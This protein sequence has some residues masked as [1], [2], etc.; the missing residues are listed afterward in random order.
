MPTVRRRAAK[1]TGASSG[2]S[3]AA[4]PASEIEPSSE[5]SVPEN[6]SDSDFE[7]SKVVGKGKRKRKDEGPPAKRKKGEIPS[8]TRKKSQEEE[9]G[10]GSL[11]EVVKTGKASLQAVVDDWIEGYK[12]DR[13]AALLE[14]I[15]FFIQCSGCRGQITPYMYANMEHAEIIRKMTEEFDE[16]SGDYPLIMTG[17]QWK[18]FRSGFCEFVQVL[19]RQCQYSIIYDQYMMDNVISLLTGL[20]DSQVRAFRHTST[21]AAMKLMTALVDVALNLSINLDNTQRQYEAERAKQQ[22]KRAGDRLELL[23]TKRQ[24]LEENQAEIRN[25]LTYIFKGVFVHRYRDT[26]PEIRSICMTEIGVWMKKYPNMFLDDSYLKYVGWTL[27][28]KVGDVRNCCLKTL[29]PLHES[30]DLASKLELFTNRF[31]DRIVEMTLDKEYDVAVQAIKLVINILKNSD[32]VLTDKDCENVYELVYSSHRQVAQAA[33]EFLNTK[34]FQRDDEATKHLKTAKGK[35]RSPNTPL[36][37]DLVQFFIESELHE[38]A[39]Y[40]VD[41][42]WEINEMMKDWECMTD[43]LLEE[44]GRGEEPLDDRQE[45]SLIEIMV[46]CVKQ[47]ATGES[48]VGRGPNR[49]LTAREAKQVAEDKTK[50][51]EHFIVTLPQLLLKYLMDPEKVANLL[52]I[53][54]YFD[55]DIYTSSRQEKNLEALLRYLHEIVEKHTDGE[56]LESCSRCFENLCSEEYAIAGK[57]DVARKTL[58]DSLVVKFRDSV[59]EFFAE[60]EQPDDEEVFALLAS[61]KR[62]YAFYCC[63]DLTNWEL[64][65]DLFHI[66]KTANE[67]AS[68]SEDIIC[69]S[70]AA[71]SMAILWYRHRINEDNPDKEQ[72]KILKQRLDNYLKNCHDLLFH[73]HEKVGAEAYVSICD[74][75][76]VFSKHLGDNP[77][78]KPLVFEVDRRLQSH[79]SNFLTEKVFVED[80]D[81]DVDENV[82][83]EELHKRRNFLACF[84]KLVVYNVISIKVAADMFKH[85]MKFYNDYG[86]IIKATLSKAREINKVNTAKTLAMSLT[87]LYKEL[88]AEQGEIDRSSDAFQS[89]KELARRFSLSFGLDQV[90]NREAVA[91]MHREGIV[92]SLTL[93]E[94]SQ[95]TTGA[96]PNLSFMEVLCEFTNKLMKQDKKTVL[97][98]LN[99]HLAGGVPANHGDEWQPLWTY[100]NSLLQGEEQINPIT[101]KQA[102]AKRYG[103]R[104]VDASGDISSSSF[105]DAQT[106]GPMGMPQMTSTATKRHHPEMDD[107]SEQ[108]SEADFDDVS[109]STGTAGQSGGASVVP[110]AQVSWMNNQKHQQQQPQQQDVQRQLD[111]NYSR[112]MQPLTQTAQMNLSSEGAAISEYDT[113]SSVSSSSSSQQHSLQYYRHSPHP[114]A[115]TSQGHAVMT[116]QPQQPLTPQQ[117]S[118]YYPHHAGG[119]SGGAIFEEGSSSQYIDDTS[120]QQQQPPHMVPPAYSDLGSHSSY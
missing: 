2:Q 105:G 91:A 19:V 111:P 97:N 73:H 81:D 80:D 100:R 84:C 85:Y 108:G 48:P 41:S 34:L 68:I 67:G 40:L 102:S 59:Q 116:P 90:K 107:M 75:L 37:R 30:P 58:I 51:T 115:M 62:I 93:P 112:H 114:Q 24:E 101:L 65:E 63:H 39:A 13:N 11:F 78:L 42:L 21:L 29:A 119:G 66:I 38:H 12:L 113:P 82:K 117:Q 118:Q 52:Q 64:W 76:I 74:L 96:P 69:R 5:V 83:I 4:E 25:M 103:K 49:K 7:E 110:P 53:P 36:I 77:N 1:E 47:A 33:G 70:V 87:Q 8:A 22:N 50:L 55:L 6:D 89:I 35:K 45:T 61:L 86:D 94:N 14:L 106:P 99:K 10:S 32:H 109:R 56:V 79:L 98:Y 88:Q 23:M 43:L 26:Q 60:G 3:H 31:K 92:F 27:Y 54:L 120:H 18:K 16:E 95:P 28:D 20:T 72:M 44:P 15:Q 46:C 104:R 17:P 9:R 71:C 57:C